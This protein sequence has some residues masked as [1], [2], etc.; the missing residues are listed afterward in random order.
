MRDYVVLYRIEKIMHPLDAPFGFI[1]A[2]DDVE[3]A[4]EQCLNAYPDAGIVWV[5]EYASY[6]ER[7]RAYQAALDEYYAMT[8][9]ADR[10]ELQP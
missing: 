2:A 7:E 5:D 10:K 9:D 6:Y 1:C 4:E 8:G 3:R